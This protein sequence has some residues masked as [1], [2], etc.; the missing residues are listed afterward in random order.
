MRE[1]EDL[2]MRDLLASSPT[3]INATNGVNGQMPTEITAQDVNNI[4]RILLGNDARTLVHSIQSTDQ[5]GT[6]SVRDAFFALCSTDITADLQSVTGVTL[7]KDYPG[8]QGDLKPEEY[9]AIS[10][11]RFFVSS[12]GAKVLNASSPSGQT[13]YKVPMYGVE[14]F[15][16]IEQN[17]YSATLGMIP[18]WAMSNVAQNYGIYAKFAIARAIENQSWLSGL[19]VTQGN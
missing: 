15:G 16:K 17:N 12:K 8:V 5:F 4:E 18:K 2:L 9:C 10:R 14:S 6:A 19:N 7:K 13:V 11:F 1:K 3:Y